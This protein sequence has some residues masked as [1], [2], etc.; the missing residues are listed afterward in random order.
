MSEYES[1][2]FSACLAKPYEV[3]ALRDILNV[4]LK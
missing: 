4:L 2:G 3:D 1:Q